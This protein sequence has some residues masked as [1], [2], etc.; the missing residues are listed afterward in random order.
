MK[1]PGDHCCAI[2][3]IA[4]MGL[5]SVVK[6]VLTVVFVWFAAQ[7]V[8]L[9]RNYQAARRT[10]LPILINPTRISS[11]AW[12]LC[13]PLLVR[14]FAGWDWIHRIDPGWT[15]HARWAPYEKTQSR[16]FWVVN[17]A[18]KQLFIADPAAA[19]DIMRRC[20]TE[21][22]KSADTYIIM[23]IYG[24]NV[25]SANGKVWEKHRRVTVPPF[26]ERVSEAVWDETG[27][28]IEGARRKWEQA[29]VVRSTQEDTTRV[30]FNVLSA[31]GF[32]MQCD[33]D[34]ESYGEGEMKKLG[35][36]L[37]YKDALGHMLNN[38]VVMIVYVLL[39]KM[40]LPSWAM[41]GSLGDMSVAKE[42]FG[43]YMKEMLRKEREGIRDGSVTKESLM[44]VLVRSSDEGAAEASATAGPV[45]TDDEIMGNLFVYNIAGHDTTAG[46]MHYAITM[47]AADPK[48]QAWLA[49]EIDDALRKEPA[50]KYSALFPKLSRCQAVMVRMD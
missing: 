34:G 29:G 12:L 31:T 3:T 22:V 41:F 10:G 17:P 45:L 23:D 2:R 50:I 18:S 14:L 38:V 43:Q 33:F 7:V 37:S 49:E 13:K 30:A 25:D 27:R 26:N 32:G 9:A 8:G 20:R 15:L 5:R 35:H 39:R 24:K 11:P 6:L 47:L 40:G 21:F 1:E 46:T 42:E 4:K 19:D 28:Q 48:W 36:R 16:A 44:S